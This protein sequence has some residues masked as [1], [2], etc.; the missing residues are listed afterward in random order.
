MADFEI[1]TKSLNVFAKELDD[2]QRMFPKEAKQLMRRAGSKARTIV[3]RKAR[4]LVRKKTGNYYKSIRRGRVWVDNSTGE[5]KVRVYTRSPHGH[6]IEKG[7]RI[8][9]KDGSEHGFKEGYHV[10][11][12]ATREIEQQWEE[13]LEKEFDKIMSKL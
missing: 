8:I 1:E 4:Q 11:D 10:F 2:L 5:Y 9:G 12:K 6:L 7:H 3:A 13:I